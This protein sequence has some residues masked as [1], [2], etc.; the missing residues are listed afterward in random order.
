MFGKKRSSS[1]QN[2]PSFWGEIL[3]YLKTQKRWWLTPIIIALLLL[4][5]IALLAG[6][7]PSLPFIYVLF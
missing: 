6:L 3:L 7:G 2:E 4:S 1:Q 5:L